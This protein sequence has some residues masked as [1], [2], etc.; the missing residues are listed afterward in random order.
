[1]DVDERGISVDDQ[2]QRDFVEHGVCWL[3]RLL[4]VCLC[5]CSAYVSVG[6]VG[7]ACM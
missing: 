1:M 2:R 4:C 6:D 3:E 5:V 7:L